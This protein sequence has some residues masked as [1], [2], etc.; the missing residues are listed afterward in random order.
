MLIAFT[1]LAG[2]F[3]TQINAGP[4][5]SYASIYVSHDKILAMCDKLALSFSADYLILCSRALSISE[6]LLLNWMCNADC[7]Q[8]VK[9]CIT[10]Y[11]VYVQLYIFRHNVDACIGDVAQL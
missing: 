2:F 3:I 4:R 9:G 1:I 7:G 8:S 5:H 11:A 6:Y 10:T